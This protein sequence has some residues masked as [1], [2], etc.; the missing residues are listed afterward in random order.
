MGRY[1]YYNDFPLGFARGGKEN[2]LKFV[3]GVAGE[4]FDEVSDLNCVSNTLL[5]SGDLLHLFGDSPHFYYLIRFLKGSNHNFKVIISP[6][7]YRRSVFLY[8]VLKL[9]PVFIP[10][11]YSDRLKLYQQVD[12]IIVNSIYEKNYLINI[13]GRFLSDKTVVVYNTFKSS[14]AKNRI[15]TPPPVQKF[16]LM[17][18]HLNERKNVFE[19]LRA[20]D[21]I[22][23]KYNLQLHIAG[24]LRFFNEKNKLKFLQMVNKRPWVIY[25]GL[26]ESEALESLYENCNFHILPSFIESPGLSNLEALARKKK[27]IV[28]D[29]PILHEYFKS[30]VI[31]TGFSSKD[32]IRSVE[33]LINSNVYSSDLDLSF[34]SEMEIS[35][36]YKRVFINLLN[37]E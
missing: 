8:K 13:F 7:F 36:H 28:G 10:N 20:S 16:Y 23:E 15:L 14:G 2:Q 11:W 31:Y 22:H 6:N 19:L 26:L 3:A 37:E 29:F 34:C 4:I 27:I 18:A 17:V 1:F 33:H 25:H 32:I 30:E 21:I 35:R 24:D 12:V 5:R 9:L